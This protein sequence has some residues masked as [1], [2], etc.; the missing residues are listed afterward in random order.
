MIA[1][2]FKDLTLLDGIDAIVV[3]D[4]DNRILDSWAVSHFNTRVFNDLAMN[5]LQIFGIKTHTDYHFDEAVIAFEKGQVYGRQ[6]PEF[7][8]IVIAKFRVEISLIRLIVNV[9]IAE[10]GS[11]RKLKKILRK[12]S[13]GD[14]DFLADTYLDDVESEYLKKLKYLK[15]R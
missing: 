6:L 8:L 3:F 7:G 5:Y 2:L 12:L 15:N 4:K 10:F 14:T 13:A 11:S 1:D 9:G